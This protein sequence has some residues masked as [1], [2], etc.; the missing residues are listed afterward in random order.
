MLDE[1]SLSIDTQTDDLVQENIWCEF[2][3]RGVTVITVAHWL[4]KVL[5]YNNILVVGNGRMP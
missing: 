1:I 2:V 4:G 3:D 5:T